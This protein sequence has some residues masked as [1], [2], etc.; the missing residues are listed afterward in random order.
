MYRPNPQFGAQEPGSNSDIKSFA[1]K[2][3]G[4]T[5]P[6]MSKVDVNGQGGEPVCKC[7]LGCWGV[8]D[9]FSSGPV[10]T[11]VPCQQILLQ[12]CT[13]GPQSFV[14][15]C[16]CLVLHTFPA[17]AQLTLCSSGSRSVHTNSQGLQH[18][19]QQQQQPP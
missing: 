11:H 19:Q 13:A 3:Y 15:T 4:V 12:V 2:N 9:S 14:L 5:F 8:A 1:K 18:V 16:P 10:Q 7:D 6:L 17:A